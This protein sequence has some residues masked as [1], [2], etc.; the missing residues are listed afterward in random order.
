MR[1]GNG[2]N[3]SEPY[4]LFKWLTKPRQHPHREQIYTE[5]RLYARDDPYPADCSGRQSVAIDHKVAPLVEAHFLPRARALT[6][7]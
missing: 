4:P 1:R 3:H 5:Q 6:G 7:S 2:V